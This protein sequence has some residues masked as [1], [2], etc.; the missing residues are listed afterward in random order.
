MNDE[1]ERFT[2]LDALPAARK[3]LLTLFG[4]L[5]IVS[6]LLGSNPFINPDYL[7]LEIEVA[8]GLTAI[9]L[10]MADR[11][12]E[13]RRSRV[14]NAMIVSMLSVAVA[15][16]S[17]EAATRWIF[18]S[19]TASADGGGYFSRRDASSVLLNEHGFRERSYAT[20]KPPGKY[21][22][23]VI[24]DSFTFGNGLDPRERYTNVLD[25]WLPDQYEVLNF[26][27]PGNN[28]PH[29]LDTLRARVLPAQPDFVLLQWFVNDIEGNDLSGR[30]R[31]LPLVPVPGLH[32]WLNANSAIYTVANM[33]WAELQI[34][35][36]MAPSYADYLKA[37]AED[38]N[39]MDARR[40]SRLLHEIIDTA[41]RAGVKIAILLF[42]DP[43]QDLGP[44][45]PFAFLHERVLGVCR[46]EAV[47]CIDLRGDLA[48]V[49]DRRALWVSPFDHHPSAK[50]NEIA[51]LKILDRLQNHWT[52]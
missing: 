30:P 32:R 27:I 43:G 14:R 8:L 19:V 52:K 40:E 44:E 26:G 23:A 10:A 41:Q 49:K 2:P 7:S 13:A 17:A 29:H 45:Y 31:T 9:F 12:P 46:Q 5:L 34:A 38:A 1:A 3:R 15:G 16:V 21:R 6:D 20:P 25:T 50:A 24:G 42:P 37:R 39:S 51:A 36:G 28:T 47:P 48:I 4:V 33:R 22:I 11:V 35:M 18:R